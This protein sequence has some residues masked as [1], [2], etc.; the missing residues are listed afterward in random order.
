MRTAYARA[1][2]P[3]LCTAGGAA[4]PATPASAAPSARTTN[5]RVGIEWKCRRDPGAKTTFPF[6]RLMLGRSGPRR[7]ALRPQLTR[8]AALGGRAGLSADQALR[9]LAASR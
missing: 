7:R 2:A 1:L 4:A 6:L 5:P 9:R 3:P 8:T